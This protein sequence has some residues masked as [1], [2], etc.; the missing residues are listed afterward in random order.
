MKTIRD[1]INLVEQDIDPS[2]VVLDPAPAPATS[3]DSFSGPELAK[4]VQIEDGKKVVRLTAQEE[5]KIRELFGRMNAIMSK[6][7]ETDDQTFE[8]VDFHSMTESEQQQYIMQN[9]HL[10]SEA[11]QMV[12]L[13]AIMNEGYKDL[14]KAAWNRV[15]EPLAKTGYNDVLKP[16]GQAV[17]NKV[18]RGVDAVGKAI[19]Y[20]ALGTGVTLGVS[21]GGMWAYEGGLKKLY[22]DIFPASPAVTQA[23]SSEDQAESRR[24]EQEWARVLSDPTDYLSN[25]GIW[26][27]YS[28]DL[29]AD[30]YEYATRWKNFSEAMAKRKRTLPTPPTPP[31]DQRLKNLIPK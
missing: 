25:N 15:I 12:V 28:D 9:L 21:L 13:R 20:T 30:I 24:I 19:G 8:S 3:Q 16:I 2:T 4:R 27:K 23:L 18:S 7:L 29:N 10:L 1:F 22:K 26:L 31:I 14:A 17:G 6:Y 11:D 5:A